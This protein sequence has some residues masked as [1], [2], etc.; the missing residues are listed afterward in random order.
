[1]KKAAYAVGIVGA[2][3]IAAVVGFVLR[4]S[5]PADLARPALPWSADD[6]RELAAKLKS[7]GLTVQAL[8]EYEQYAQRPP[9][10]RRAYANLCYTIG[11]MHMDAGAY[12]QALAWFYRVEIAD[13]NTAL[14]N[15]LG[16]H[17]VACLERA[18]KYSAAEHTLGKR[19][20]L[21]PR[22]ERTEGTVIAEIGSDKIYR[23]DINEAFDRMPPWLRSQFDGPQGRREFAQ[24]YIADE[25]LY[26]KAL[27][28]GYDKDPDLLK[29]KKD[30]ERDL[31]VAKVI[32]HDVKES[33]AVD[34]HDI[35]TYFEAHR[36]DYADKDAVKVSL[37]KTDSKEAAE[38]IIRRVKAGGDFHQIARE[39]SL[40]KR[41]AADGGRFPSWV[42]NGEDDLGIGNTAA[43]SAALFGAKPGDMTQ[44]VPVGGAWYVFRIEETRP[45]RMPDYAEVKDRVKNDCML[46]K[47]QARYQE[48]LEQTLKSGDVKLHLDAIGNDK[49]T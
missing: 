37:I 34:E 3:C 29:K 43:V 21:E 32:E 7:A 25:L 4:S 44:P 10:D 14:K 42:R 45:G 15:E 47:T 46:R 26:R 12:E 39:L 19:A 36:N 33:V 31:L 49:K 18:G 9:L 35:K 1:M 38:N 48:L 8:R 30:I 13:P 41:T 17:I 23:E 20:A 28:L 24:K 16:S 2:C 5:L 27:K 40:D 11:K 22:T 6:Q